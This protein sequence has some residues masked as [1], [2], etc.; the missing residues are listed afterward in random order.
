[1]KWKN[2][3]NDSKPRKVMPGENEGLDMSPFERDY[4]TIV[5]SSYFR[6]LQKK[7]QVYVLDESDFIRTRL[8]H[9]LEVSAIAEMLGKR[10]GEEIRKHHN[11]DLPENFVEKLSLVLRCAGLLHDLGNPPFGHSGEEY[12]RDF[13]QENEERLRADLTDQMWLDFINFDGNAHNFRIVTKLGQS[14]NPQDE[15]YGMG[16][17]NAVLNSIIKYPYTSLVW[18]ERECNANGKKKRGKIGYYHSED[19][20]AEIVMRETG[21]V[22]KGRVMK[23]PVMMLMEAADDIAYATADVEDAIKKQEVTIQEIR[24]ILPEEDAE[25]INDKR[26]EANIRELQNV[27]KQ[28]RETAVID[29]VKAFMDN[30]EDIM[31]GCY[32]GELVANGTYDLSKLKV[33]LY[34]VYAERDKSAEIRYDSQK[35]VTEILDYLVNAVLK[36]GGERTFAE[37]VLLEELRQYFDKGD[38]E[39]LHMW[40]HEIDPRDMSEEEKE[41]EKKKEERYHKYMA[42]VDFV[43]GMTDSYVNIFWNKIYNEDYIKNQK[44]KYKQ[45]CLAALSR[46]SNFVEANEI[47]GRVKSVDLWN[48]FEISVMLQCFLNNSQVRGAYDCIKMIKKLYKVYDSADFSILS[49]EDEETLKEFAKSG[50][51]NIG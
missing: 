51:E 6:R 19:W 16:L 36:D 48:N 23:N 11:E 15:R 32:E 8:T 3:L 35:Q 46:A 24:A 47:M 40:N 17:T 18:K 2:L 33:A 4:Y 50:W 29:V 13:F 42:I 43:S 49:R 25:K 30:Y 21:T 7:T 41:K 5:T 22:S 14:S 12:I 20:I 9:S 45:E 44:L 37:N 38:R 34:G 10:V 1:M 31:N 27:L 26:D 28:I 39:V